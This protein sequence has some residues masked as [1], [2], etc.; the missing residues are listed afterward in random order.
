M[1]PVENPYSPGAGLRP[2]ELA[3]RDDE[4]SRFA[5]LRARARRGRGAQSIV[6]TGL[7]GVGKT[8]LLNELADAARDDGWIVAKVEA[9]SSGGRTPFRNQVAASLNVALRRLQ[10]KTGKGSF[11]E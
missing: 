11:K 8:V 7:R 1:D 9:E 5:V 6:V 4:I 10:G 3:G 2:E